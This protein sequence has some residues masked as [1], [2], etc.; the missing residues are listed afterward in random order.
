MTILPDYSL[1]ERERE[2]IRLAE[3]CL[4]ARTWIPTRSERAIAFDVG[5]GLRYPSN[6]F[7]PHSDEPT[8]WRL[9]RLARWAPVIRLALM[10]SGRTTPVGKAD[11]P[12]STEAITLADLLTA[13][14]AVAGITEQWL[15]HYT[16]AETPEGLGDAECFFHGMAEML[17]AVATGDL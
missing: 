10:A 17:T 4:R 7:P 11:L 12:A 2:W 16:G 8:W 6:A 5:R 13:V 3:R 9:Q 14:Y 1:S 15:D